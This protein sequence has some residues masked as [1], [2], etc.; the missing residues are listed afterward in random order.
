ML[1]ELTRGALGE[2][3]ALLGELRPSDPGA[4]ASPPLPDAGLARLPRGGLLAALRA[5]VES[6]V[7]GDLAVHV[8]DEGYFAQTPAREEALYRIAR[9]ALHNVVKHARAT[10][11]DVRIGASAGVLRLSVR[12]DGAG[13]DTHERGTRHAGGG[14]L[15]L[16]SMRERAVEQGGTL[17][18]ESAPGRGTLVEAAMPLHAEGMP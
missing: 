6:G 9:E 15:G 12:D 13:F 14:G 7:H 8:E 3:R 18:I 10:R 17:R 5:H 16:L 1:V 2:M 4:S 11:A